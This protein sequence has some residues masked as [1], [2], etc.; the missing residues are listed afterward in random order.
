LNP[1]YLKE[2]V[3][4]KK[5]YSVKSLDELPITAISFLTTEG[6]ETGEWR[7]QRPVLDPEKCNRCGLCW[8]YCP[9]NAIR[10]EGSAYQISYK[11]CKGCGICAEECPKGA[12]LIIKEKR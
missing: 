2:F 8:M 10:T 1:T 11:Y 6:N 5:R 12:I 7:S 9:D 3:K 4:M